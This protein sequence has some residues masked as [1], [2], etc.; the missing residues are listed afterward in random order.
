MF[1]ADKSE[2]KKT[3]WTQHCNLTIPATKAVTTHRR[4]AS[5]ADGRRVRAEGCEGL[6]RKSTPQSERSSQKFDENNKLSTTLSLS[7]NR[8]QAT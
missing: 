3:L 2:Q 8:Q 4:S 5:E 1:W 7:G 6:Q